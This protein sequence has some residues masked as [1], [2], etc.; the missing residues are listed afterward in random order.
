[1]LNFRH[2]LHGKLIAMVVGFVLIP[3]LALGALAVQQ[4][5]KS[6]EQQAIQHLRQVTTQT[7]SQIHSQLEMLEANLEQLSKSVLLTR[8]L[9]IENETDRLLLMQPMLLELLHG[10]QEVFQDYF[11]IRVLLP[12]GF[13]DTR[14]ITRSIPNVRDEEA[15]TPFFKHLKAVGTASIIEISTNEDIEQ[16]AVMSGKGVFLRN[17]G[18][19]PRW[20]KDELRGYIAVSMDLGTIRDLISGVTQNSRITLGI[21]DLE[22]QPIIVNRNSEESQNWSAVG[23]SAILQSVQTGRQLNTSIG[24]EDYILMAH[25]I[26]YGLRI[27]GIESSTA[28]G[29]GS[30]RLASWLIAGVIIAISVTIISVLFLLRQLIIRPVEILDSAARKIRDGNLTDPVLVPANRRDELADF[31]RS[32]ENMRIGL[33]KNHDALERQ[34]HAME[35]AKAEAEAANKAKSE[36]LATMSHEIRTPMNGVIGMTGLLRTTELTAEQSHFTDTIRYSG[37]ALM[38]IINDIL[39]FSK[40]EAERLELEE[41]DFDLFDLIESTK[42]MLSPRARESGLNFTFFIPSDLH[43]N[44]RGDPGR[45]GQVLINLLSNAIKFTEKGDVSLSLS[46]PDGRTDERIKLRFE[47][48]DTG[49]GISD[50]ALTKLFS[51]FT[52]VDA[53]TTRKYGGTGLGLAISEKLVKA[54]GGEIGVE[55]RVGEGSVFWFEVEMAYQEHV[56]SFDPKAFVEE[57]SRC[58]LLIVDDNPIN[59]EIFQKTLEHWGLNTVV[60][61]DIRS[62]R[63]RISQTLTDGRSFDLILLDN[64]MPDL[65][66]ID[67]AQELRAA[68]EY[69]NV[70]IVLASSV[71]LSKEERELTRTIVQGFVLKPAPR[72]TLFNTII[73]ALGL[74]MENLREE[75]GGD[76]TAQVTRQG[77]DVSLRILVAEDNMVNQMVV[78]A[79]LTR[80]NHDV[81]LAANGREALEMAEAFPFDLI[82]MDMQM[83][84]MDGMEAT[85]AI[86]ALPTPAADIPIIAL[87]ANAF[88]EFE[89]QC[90][91]AGMNGFITKPVSVEELAKFL[92]GFTATRST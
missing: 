20:A 78:K 67:F 38:T 50:E 41:T 15:E 9:R 35:V 82:F 17:L 29:A 51:R 90:R 66:G 23:H 42:E 39:D 36:F 1:M 40:L 68:P 30:A 69:E 31:G 92:E 91:E 48:R 55:S 28:I 14:S 84:E 6:G 32:L 26:G 88:S 44:L 65:S 5:R 74:E 83:P 59:R 47:V 70:P 58:R 2:S 52:Q 85:R 64:R 60:C 22:G 61:P 79:I 37:E 19:T 27:V 87:T 4:M 49:I 80:F 62:A 45:L 12:D 24:G 11:E 73:S 71:P 18:E 57:F 13:E 16:K 54:M 76:D 53:S 86:R 77:P 21:Y 63:E 75:V 81:E 7:G 3:L 10:Y 34:Y 25:E 33:L 89:V 56:N 43:L 46:S 72:S 8:Y